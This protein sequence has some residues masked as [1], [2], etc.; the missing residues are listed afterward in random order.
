MGKVLYLAARSVL[1]PTDYNCFK[2]DFKAFHNSG[3]KLF[4]YSVEKFLYE[5]GV[6]YECGIYEPDYIN[7]HYERVIITPANILAKYAKDKLVYYYKLIKKLK[8]PVIFL[9]IGIQKNND[10]DFEDLKKDVGKET[11]KLA[12]AVYKTGGEFG[13]RGYATKEFMDLIIPDNTAVVTGCPSVYMNKD[14]CITNEKVEHKDFKP[15][16]NG[17]MFYLRGKNFYSLFEKYNNAVYI[18][19]DEFA[20]ILL[21]RD[22]SNKNFEALLSDYS[23]IGIK[24]L[25]E[26]RLKFFYDITDWIN[27]IKTGGFNFSFGSRIHGNILPILAGVP[28]VVDCQDS[29]TAEICDFYSIPRTKSGQNSDLYDI[30]LNA[31]YSEFNKNFE[32]HYKNYKDFMKNHGLCTDITKELLTE[33][34]DK[35]RIFDYYNDT[36]YLKADLEKF[37]I[38][39]FSKKYDYLKFMH[40]ITLG[41]PRRRYKKLYKLASECM[42][43]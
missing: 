23:Y 40:N 25:S 43:L 19:Q 29:R 16:I 20:D 14:L 35:I 15:L 6:D 42:Y 8:V 22:Y 26:D 5:N 10:S 38:K 30:Y 41:K 36:S 31:D 17:T 32:T 28:A 33:V 11:K 7:N 12:E 34:S 3:N 21:H 4:Q 27:Y 24:L 9:S 37:D 13:L 1:K 39:E 18:D 2:Q